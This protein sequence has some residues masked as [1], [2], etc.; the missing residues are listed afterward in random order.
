MLLRQA[1][2]LWPAYSRSKFSPQPSKLELRSS[3]VTPG[4][5]LRTTRCDTQLNPRQLIKEG[6][7]EL[8]ASES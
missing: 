3:S 7:V 2:A 6:N 8:M 4:Q 5:A 1:L